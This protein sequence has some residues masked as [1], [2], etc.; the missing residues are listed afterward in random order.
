MEILE[1]AGYHLTEL[2]GRRT[3]SMDPLRL[4]RELPPG[5]SRNVLAIR[6]APLDP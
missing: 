3:V 2:D 4:E 5:R 1:Q 6:S